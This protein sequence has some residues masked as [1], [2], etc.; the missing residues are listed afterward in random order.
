MLSTFAL[1]D[2][3]LMQV[4]IDDKQDLTRKD[5]IW[6]D[7]AYPSDEERE[8]VQ[9]VFPLE[10]PEDEELQ[11]LEASAR[12]YQDEQG[13]H[14]RSTF[15]QI[16]DDT[17]SVVTMSFNLHQGRLLT[18]HDDDLTLLRLFRMQARAGP[19][20]V[21]DAIDILLGCYGL[22]VE[23]DA[24][25]LEN[26][27]KAL[28]EVGALLL[29]R[30]KEI[31]SRVM[32]DNVERIA[33]QEDLNSK[34]RL[35]LMDNRR[36]LS[37]LLRSRLLSREQTQEVKGILRDIESL[38]GHTGFIFDKINFLMDAL[39]GMINL[40]QNKIIKI[41][42]IAAVVFL[43]PTLVASIYGMNFENMSE[44]KWFW[45]YPIA[46]LLMI[47][48]GAAPYVHFKRKGWLD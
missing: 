3:R 8:L 5:L 40:E 43:P 42:S 21:D 30:K 22:G 36:A 45:G 23:H 31:T 39:L 28:D 25:V 34:V 2:G 6:I 27:Y 18:V 9:S 19:G 15:I 38:N 47:G 37:F 7:L 32:R 1:N 35:D 46:I 14:I 24:D 4:P 48:A 12:Y 11:A 10:L 41:F 26:I 13:I 33:E 44:I 16:T 29:D 20:I 17:P